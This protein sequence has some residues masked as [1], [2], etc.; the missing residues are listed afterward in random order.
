[1]NPNPLSVSRLI[2]PVVLAMRRVLLDAHVCEVQR[3]YSYA[4]SHFAR[5]IVQ[6]IKLRLMSAPGR[7]TPSGRPC[8]RADG[9]PFSRWLGRGSP[10]GRARGGP[11]PPRNPTNPNPYGPGPLPS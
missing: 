5:E 11:G 6:P 2:V 10:A 9:G 3:R 7:G 4:V 8:S 1:M